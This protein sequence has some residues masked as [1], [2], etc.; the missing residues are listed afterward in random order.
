MDS[1]GWVHMQHTPTNVFIECSKQSS[2]DH[3]NRS[4]AYLSK[5]SGPF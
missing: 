1:L 5:A 3:Q 2:L 4:C